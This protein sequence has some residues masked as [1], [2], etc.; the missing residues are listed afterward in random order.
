MRHALAL[1]EA[2]AALDAVLRVRELKHTR[3]RD[4]VV[5]G[6]YSVQNLCLVRGRDAVVR[7]ERGAQILRRKVT[8]GAAVRVLRAWRVLR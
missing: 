6:L 8:K 2:V 3:A 5:P 1:A 7:R 4:M